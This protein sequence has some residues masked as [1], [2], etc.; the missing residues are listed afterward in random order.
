MGKVV[1]DVVDLKID[2]DESAYTVTAIENGLA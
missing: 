1:G 2:G